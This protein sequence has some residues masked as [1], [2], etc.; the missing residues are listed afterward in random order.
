MQLGFVTGYT[1]FEQ[2]V[3]VHQLPKAIT[4]LAQRMVQL[5]I[6]GSEFLRG[7]GAGKLGVQVIVTVQ[8][9]TL[10]WSVDG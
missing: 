8:G 9:N 7:G 5:Q 4:L 3:P 1:T 6:F 2:V 10:D